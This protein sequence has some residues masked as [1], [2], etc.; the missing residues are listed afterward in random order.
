[1]D[2]R[3]K[4]IRIGAKLTQQQF[5]DKLG[6]KRGAIANYEIG[7]N[8]P[9][10]AVISLICDKFNVNEEWLRTGKGEMYRKLDKEQEIAEMVSFLFK[11][12]S[13]SFKYRFVKAVCNMNDAGW[14]ALESLINEINK[15]D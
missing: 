14:D 9:I 15:K 2:T 5:A 7:R 13:A 3:I 1:M 10:D 11:E 12:E 4:Q 6:I 8:T